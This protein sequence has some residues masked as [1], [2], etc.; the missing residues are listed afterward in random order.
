MNED[1]VLEVLETL[2]GAGV[3]AWLDGGWG[4]DALLGERTR[5]HADLTIG[6]LATGSLTTGS[7]TTGSSATG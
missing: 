2:E 3:R 5:E 1:A 6:S 4:V 7:L